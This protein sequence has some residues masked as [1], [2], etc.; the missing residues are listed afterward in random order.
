[1]AFRSPQSSR[2]E[3]NPALSR[4]P[5]VPDDAERDTCSVRGDFGG[6]TRFAL[7]ATGAESAD[8]AT[9][10]RDLLDVQ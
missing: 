2:P 7:G 5:I 4:T 10:I 6:Q 3:S 9:L 8:R 1:M